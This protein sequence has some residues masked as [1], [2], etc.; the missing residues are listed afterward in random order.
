M[1][2]IEDVISVPVNQCTM[3]CN[4]TP[5]DELKRSILENDIITPLNA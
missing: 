2:V 1:H 3:Y 5:S 4:S